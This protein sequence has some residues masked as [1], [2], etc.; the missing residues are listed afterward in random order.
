MSRGGRGRHGALASTEEQLKDILP[1]QA[2]II[3]LGRDRDYL[4]VM[5][6]FGELDAEA[7]N[8]STDID[9]AAE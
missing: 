6:L 1:K 5:M 4:T 9:D 3:G 2:I 8:V 7:A